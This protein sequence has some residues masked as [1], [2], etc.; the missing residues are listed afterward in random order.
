V[1]VTLALG[2]V[3]NPMRP[4]S[5]GDGMFR[6]KIWTAHGEPVDSADT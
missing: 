2:T 5:W 4:M 6:W 3:S 1:S